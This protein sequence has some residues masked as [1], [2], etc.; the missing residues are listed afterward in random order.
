MGA[1][2]SDSNNN[3]VD[4]KEN[5]SDKRLSD[6]LI[7]LEIT[8]LQKQTGGIIDSLNEIS[9][10]DSLKL[11]NKRYT[12]YDL[13]KILKELD[14]EYQTGGNDKEA[15]NDSTLN[16]DKS[17]EHIKNVILKELETL[18]NNQTKQVGGVNCDCD[19]KIKK[20][21]YKLNLNNI[22]IDDQ[23]GGDFIINDSSSS[24]KK[25]KADKKSK[26]NKKSKADK[27]S[28]DTSKKSK[29]DKKSNDT[30]KKSKDSK[31]NT[32]KKSKKMSNTSLEKSDSSEFSVKT[33]ESETTISSSS[34]SNH[35]E[36]SKYSDSSKYFIRD[37]NTDISHEYSVKTSNSSDKKSNISDKK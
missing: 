6:S 34:K 33:S 8:E 18:K 36:S 16:D 11:E 20:K 35:D 3:I 19:N 2:F 17:I 13:F 37:S 5:G 4:I 22:I 1:F 23:L 7:S 14:S 10:I 24:K 15:T 32:K 30:S 29:A 25:S 28:N 9:N 31:K 27:K 26:A 21:S 12:K